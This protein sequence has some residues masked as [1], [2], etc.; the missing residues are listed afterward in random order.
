M[1]II[2]KTKI[3]YLTAMLLLTATAYA[4]TQGNIVTFQNNTN[5]VITTFCSQSNSLPCTSSQACSLTSYYPNMSVIAENKSMIF[6]TIGFLNYT[7]GVLNVTGYYP[8]FVNCTDGIVN[9]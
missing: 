1:V 5:V 3:Y 4:V 7:L 9:G 2:M 6:S 8:T